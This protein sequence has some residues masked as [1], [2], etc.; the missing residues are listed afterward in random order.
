MTQWLD[1]EDA[2]GPPH[3]VS[4]RVKVL[5]KVHSPQLHNRRDL[6]VYLPPSI[7]RGGAD[8]PVLYMQDGQNLFDPATSFA[9]DWALDRTMDAAARDGTEAII[10]AIPNMGE[11]RIDEYS[12]FHDPKLGGGKGDA[13]IAFV[14]ETVKP[15]IDRDFPTR[16]A[17]A[18]TGLGGSSM[19]GLISLYGFFERPDTFNLCLAMSPSLWFASRAVLERVRTLD[20]PHGRIYL[21]IGIRENRTAI[22]DTR[23]LRDLLIDVGYRPGHDLTF[24]LDRHGRHH[25]QD[26][27]RRFAGALRFLWRE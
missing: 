19:G 23:R 6:L 11:S 8:Y 22:A 3:A 7:E 27:G 17:P 9:G 2:Y 20:R 13:Y 10:V 15:L 24:V 4:G 14:A 12:P 26:W 16:P 18:A 1:Y 25:E 5:R 21:D